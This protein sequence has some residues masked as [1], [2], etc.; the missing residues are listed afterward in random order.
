MNPG[1]VGA[2]YLAA[3]LGGDDELAACFEAAFGPAELMGALHTQ[4]RVLG[5]RVATDSDRTLSQLGD[6]LIGAAVLLAR[7]DITF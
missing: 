1:I 6:D 3:M 4:L 2:G 7:T 5:R